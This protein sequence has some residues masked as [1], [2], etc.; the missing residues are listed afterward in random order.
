M[1]FLLFSPIL[2]WTSILQILI[3][4]LQKLWKSYTYDQYG[5]NRKK[6]K[7]SSMIWFYLTFWTKHFWLI[8]L[9]NGDVE[10]EA[11]KT[12]NITKLH[13]TEFGPTI[14]SIN[15]RIV[16]RNYRNLCDLIFLKSLNSVTIK[17][18]HIT[19]KWN[20][21]TYFDVLCKVTGIHNWNSITR[22][23]FRISKFKY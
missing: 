20:R 16:I 1:V 14:E 12:Y 23:H 9:P 11:V 17:S 3:R 2:I 21:V 19:L 15:M 5:L 13:N 18:N 4:I 22:P 6:I 8:G 10:F 7:M